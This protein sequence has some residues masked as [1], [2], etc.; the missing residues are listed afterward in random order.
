MLL[1]QSPVQACFDAWMQCETLLLALGEAGVSLSRKFTKV[2]DECAHIC[3][4]TFQALKKGADDTPRLA[5]LCVGICEECAELLETRSEAP[6]LHCARTCR[7][8]SDSV[9][10]L[11]MQ[12]L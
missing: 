4:G 3:M 8:C 1:T 10:A 5:I 6:F 11:A 7:T 9:S 2:L 12:A